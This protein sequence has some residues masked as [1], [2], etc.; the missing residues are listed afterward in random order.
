MNERITA[1]P[2]LADALADDHEDAGADDGADAERGQVQRADRALEPAL[3]LARLGVRDQLP[4][5]LDRPRT[6]RP[7]LTSHATSP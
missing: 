5:V 4:V 1:G 6:A 3:L 7:M 2:G